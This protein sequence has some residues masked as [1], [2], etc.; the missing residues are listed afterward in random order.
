MSERAGRIDNA[1]AEVEHVRSE[2]D[3]EITIIVQR[4]PEADFIVACSAFVLLRSA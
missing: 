2:L 3:K 4:R 1:V